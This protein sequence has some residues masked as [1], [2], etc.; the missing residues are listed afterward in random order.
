VSKRF[1][2]TIDVDIRDSQ[3]DWEPYLQLVAP[4]E[5]PLHRPRRRQLLGNEAVGRLGTIKEAVVDLTG[6]EYV[7]LEREALEVMKRE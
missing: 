2:G 1:G 5:R 3:P 6:D 7:D 4:S